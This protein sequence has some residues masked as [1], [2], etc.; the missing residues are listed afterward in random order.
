MAEKT[1]ETYHQE[2]DDL[3]KAL[4]AYRKENELLQQE[5][6]NFQGEGRKRK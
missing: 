6:Q 2:R 3:R 4:E 5:I 1:G